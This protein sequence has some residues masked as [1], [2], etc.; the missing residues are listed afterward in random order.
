MSGLNARRRQD[1]TLPPA[2]SGAKAV[3]EYESVFALL[4]AYANTFQPAVREVDIR[5]VLHGAVIESTK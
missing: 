2:G 3:D 5:C 4:V 1:A